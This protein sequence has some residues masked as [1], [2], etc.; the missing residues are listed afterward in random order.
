MMVVSKQTKKAARP[1]SV[2][3]WLDAYI[4]G[5]ELGRGECVCAMALRT[6]RPARNGGKA[7]R[8][9]TGQMTTADYI[10]DAIASLRSK[11]RK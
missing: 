2:R 10:Q 7:E 1:G 4:A 3:A 11:G 9:R 6:T 5:C 8:R